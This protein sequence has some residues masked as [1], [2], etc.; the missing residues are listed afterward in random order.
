MTPSP[1]AMEIAANATSSTTDGVLDDPDHDYYQES[2]FHSLITVLLCGVI[3]T[4]V[5]VLFVP[6]AGLDNSKLSK[7]KQL[8][9][10][11]PTA[12]WIVWFPFAFLFGMMNVILFSLILGNLK[13]TALGFRVFIWLV[14]LGIYFV[15]SFMNS[16]GYIMAFF[17]LIS[18]YFGLSFLYAKRILAVS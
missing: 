13:W 16:F 11:Q 6:L 9:W 14:S 18:L 3:I 2:W 1:E 5:I 15:I 12:N 8:V 17:L 7:G 10:L 4:T